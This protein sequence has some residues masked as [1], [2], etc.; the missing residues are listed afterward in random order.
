[1][2]T[3]ACIM[4]KCKNIM[5][6]FVFYILYTFLFEWGCGGV[7]VSTLDFRSEGQWFDAQSLPSCCF[8]RQDAL[9]H[10]VSLHPGVPKKVTGDILLG[11]NPAMD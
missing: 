8:L 2:K 11:G 6:L 10:I 4:A 5:H 3:H 1:M 7:V 9:P